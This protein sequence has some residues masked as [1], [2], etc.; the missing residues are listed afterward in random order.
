VTI[1]FAPEAEQDFQRDPEALWVVRLHHQSRP[2][3]VR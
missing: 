2:P 3:I 1:Y